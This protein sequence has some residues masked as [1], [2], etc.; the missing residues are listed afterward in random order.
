MENG[1][2][3]LFETARIKAEILS[4]GDLDLVIRL[5]ETCRDFFFFQNGLPPSENDAREIFE[6]LPPQSDGVTKL[7]IGIF[8]SGKLVGVMDVL[9]GYRTSS[10]WYIGFMLLAPSVRGQG[11][12]SEIHNEFASY[13]RRQGTHRLLLAV[14]EANESARRFWTRLGYNE[15]KDYPPRN[16]GKHLHACTEFE[17]IL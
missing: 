2:Q 7:P 10:E 9:R 3:I 16:F 11:F 4:A 5:N 15:V 17:L 12:G 13:A 8:N 6:F 14:L 1:R